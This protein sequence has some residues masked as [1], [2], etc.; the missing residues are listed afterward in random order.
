MHCR[1]G[2]VSADLTS[3][4]PPTPSRL[5]ARIALVALAL[6]VFAAGMWFA[7]LGWD[8]EYYE[9]DGVA[10]GPYRPWQVIGCGVSIVVATVVAYLRVRSWW[11]VVPLAAAATLGFA[12]PWA[13]DAAG[14]DE[15]G[16]WV[17]GLLFLLVGS[18][19]GLAVLLTV[20]AA[21]VSA[22]RPGNG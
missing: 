11:A 20:T 8:H 3:T 2:H 9:V 15:S 1:L 7:W 4:P 21:I 22:R 16:L 5:A 17:V 12:V 18:G 14:S 6:A 19:L 10:Q 13:V